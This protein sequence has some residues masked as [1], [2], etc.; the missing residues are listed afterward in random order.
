MN[1]QF[2]DFY[3]F[4]NL[5]Y[6]SYFINLPEIVDNTDVYSKNVTGR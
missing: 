5:L 1:V 2:R 6:H 4:Q 3:N